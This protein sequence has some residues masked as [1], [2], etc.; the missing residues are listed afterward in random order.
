MCPRRS[1]VKPVGEILRLVGHPS[2]AEFHDAH[3]VGRYAV[4]GQ[5]EFGDPEIAAAVN[6]PNLES[7]SVGLDEP[8]LLNVV[9]AADAFAR[10][11]I[12]EHGVLAV[13]FMLGVEIAGVGSIPMALERRPH[14]SIIH[15]DS[16]SCFRRSGATLATFGESPSN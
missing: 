14:A 3:H 16:F 4:V 12:V 1:R 11:R 5:H 6:A 7:L 13:D 15:P 2:F 8:A 10:L 9:P